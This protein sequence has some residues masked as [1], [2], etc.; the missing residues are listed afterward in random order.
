MP[1]RK[2]SPERKS[3]S[4]PTQTN[5]ARREAGRVRLSMWWPADLVELLDAMRGTRTR[6]DALQTLARM[7][8]DASSA[9]RSL[10]NDE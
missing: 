8:L 3:R 10:S 9:A 2:H 6:S 7:A 4:G 1:A 5:E